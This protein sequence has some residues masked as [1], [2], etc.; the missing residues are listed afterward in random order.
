MRWLLTAVAVGCLGG[1]WWTHSAL[2]F[3]LCLLI[4]VVSALAAA[5]AF[6]HERIEGR[7]QAELISDAEIEALKAAVRRKR[8]M[9]SRTES[10]GD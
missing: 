5:L 9:G 8:E 7:A 4:G 3:G 2:A 10:G 6:A 1:A